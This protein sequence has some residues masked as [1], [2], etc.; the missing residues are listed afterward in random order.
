MESGLAARCAV[1]GVWCAGG[2]IRRR[3]KRRG[4][5]AAPAVGASQRRCKLITD[6]QRF[7]GF[8]FLALV[9]NPQKENP[10]QLRDIL[11]R[12]GTIRPPHDV[13]N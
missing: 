5:P 10:G 11:Q 12:P 3:R 2:I 1:D 9:E 6:G 7:L 8:L 13:A 4:G